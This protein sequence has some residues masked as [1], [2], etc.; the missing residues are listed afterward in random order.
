MYPKENRTKLMACCNAL[1]LVGLGGRGG[2]GGG[3][4]DC[5]PPSCF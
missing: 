3:G 4:G 5:M 2:G 1:T